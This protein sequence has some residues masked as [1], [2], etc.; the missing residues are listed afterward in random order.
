[1]PKSWKAVQASS[2]FQ[3]LDPT[4]QEEAR[5]QY[6]NE[7][8]APQIADP[9][10]VTAAKQEFDATYG[11]KK[12]S[13]QDADLLTHGLPQ[14]PAP[15]QP[16]DRI[17]Q[18]IKGNAAENIPSIY[19]E[20]FNDAAGWGITG[21]MK[22]SMAALLG[23][24]QDVERAV[25]KATPGASMSQDANGNPVVRLKNGERYYLNEPGLDINDLGRAAGKAMLFLPAAGAAG[26][27]TTTTGRI[28]AGAAASGGTDALMQGGASLAGGDLTYD[29]K[30]G[31]IATGLGGA[32]EL[33]PAALGAAYR[34]SKAALTSD[35]KAALLGQRVAQESNI[36][37]KLTMEDLVALG[38]RYPEIQAG[39]SPASALA[40]SEFGFKLTQGQK[41]GNPS[42]LRR[43][44]ML[45]SL[46]GD[47]RASQQ[48]RGVYEAQEQ[49]LAD[50]AQRIQDYLAGGK[51][52]S[53]PAEAAQTVMG[54]V[55]QQAAD[56][57]GQIN[58]AYDVART[59]N[60]TIPLGHINDLSTKI[61]NSLQNIPVDSV[62]TPRTSR[63]LD[64]LSEDMAKVSQPGV[65]G[66]NMRAVEA[67]RQKMMSAMDGASGA[68]LKALKN[69][70]DAYDQW[71]SDA[72]DK[73]LISGDPDALQAVQQARSL[74]AQYGSRFQPKNPNDQ[75][76]KIVKRLLDDNASPDEMAQAIFGAGQLAPQASASVVQKLKAAL[77]ND[78]DAWN[79]VR[80]A[81]INK[82]VTN[83]AGDTL[84]PQAIVG[85][86]N[87]LLRE[88]PELVKQLYSPDEIAKLQRFGTAM[89]S[90]IP[91]KEIAR[92]SGT[93]ER[94][95]AYFN[96]YLSNVPGGKMLVNLL[97]TPGRL[98]AASKLTASVTQPI[99]RWVPGGLSGVSNIAAEQYLEPS[100][101]SLDAK[102][103]ADGR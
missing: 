78:Q 85:N 1:M 67:G 43:E 16:I 30:Q 5:Q 87:R 90:L 17:S 65:T 60:A 80:S 54:S 84:G 35:T 36:P 73:A 48:A 25:L 6:F 86:L 24:D 89:Q 94:G 58:D 69:V 92:S 77:G 64:L 45:R 11:P 39:A 79:A 53:S 29:P 2:Q 93:A 9:S 23:G 7:V 20:K 103:K 13:Q 97:S 42:L 46:S 100:S 82:A 26:L 70:K 18:M 98:S 49:N 34:G 15:Q 52:P 56:L 41:T 14:K 4:Q 66:V 81:F 10:Q 27:A 76:G 99:S 40:E 88:R 32:S 62:L 91:P 83:R 12:L 59:K 33:V 61:R 22:P 101:D 71:V 74:R 102:S 75:G 72:F 50:Q 51:S 31:A 28:L 63:A 96:E 3:Q 44:E 8:V 37:G 55:R 95:L 57:K 21:G 19:D 68:D 38:R 47:T